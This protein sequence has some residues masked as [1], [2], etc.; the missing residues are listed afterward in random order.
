MVTA[1]GS[2]ARVTPRTDS[3]ENGDGIDRPCHYAAFRTDKKGSEGYSAELIGKRVEPQY[4][5]DLYE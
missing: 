1:S 3:D 2:A 5:D 4:Y